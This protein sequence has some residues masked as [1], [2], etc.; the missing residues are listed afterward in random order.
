VRI[1]DLA[2]RLIRLAGLTPGSD[3][4]IEYTGRR[5]GEKLTERLS[6]DPMAL[7]R[8]P[9]I[10]EARLG[11]P[12]AYV[13][14]DSVADLEDAARDGNQAEVRRLLSGLANAPIGLETEASAPDFE[15][16]WS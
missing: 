14:L 9:Q 10:F 16:Q 4:A 11:H 8:N 2:R 3:I 1:V 15:P 12:T 6:T 7:T 13:V 5:P